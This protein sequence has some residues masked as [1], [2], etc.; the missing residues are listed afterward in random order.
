MAVVYLYFSPHWKSLFRLI[1]LSAALGTFVDGLLILLG[2]FSF[3]GSALPLWLSPLWLTAM[4]VN[5]A[6]TLRISMSWLLGRYRLGAVMG[7]LGG[8]AAYYAGAGLGAIEFQSSLPLALILLAVAW[9][10]AMPLLLYW[11]RKDSS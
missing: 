4:W 3:T 6:L 1:L 8:P 10:G 7:A 11:A 2:V 9:S 5:F